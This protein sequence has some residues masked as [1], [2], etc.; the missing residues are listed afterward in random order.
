MATFKDSGNN[1]WLVSLDAPKIKAVRSALNGFD[2]VD[3]EGKAFDRMADDPC[4]LVDVLWILCRSQAPAKNI[5]D[6]QFGALLIGEAIERA[7]AAMLESIADFFQPSK[8]KLLQAVAEKN[9]RIREAGTERALAKI[10]D[11]KLEQELLAAMDARMDAEVRAAL[12][13]LNFASGTAESSASIPTAE[14]SA[15]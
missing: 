4:L 13:R 7:T 14:P 10:N 5:S 3:P 11:P 8:R 1:E 9:R 12:T 6:E 15:S 2:I